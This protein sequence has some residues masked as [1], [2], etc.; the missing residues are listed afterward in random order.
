[1]EAVR[2]GKNMGR[3]V[4]YDLMR[5]ICMIFAISIHTNRSFIESAFWAKSFNTMLFS[6]N[7]IFYMLSGRF[8]LN[9][10]FLCKE[11]YKKYYWKKTISILY[12]YVFVTCILH[13]WDTYR[14]A[15]WN[16]IVLFIKT[17][18]VALMNSNVSGPLWFM[19]P[20]IGMLI[21]TPFLARMF[22][23]LSDWELN[24]LFCLSLMWNVVSIY[25]TIDF[26]I[27][28]SY[29]GFILSGW[30]I[31]FFA[32]YYCQRIV[33][34][35]NKKKFYVAGL[36]G[37]IVTVLGQVL[38]PD[39]YCNAV[40]LAPAFVLFTIALFIFMEK[41]IKISNNVIRR[42]IGSV[43]RHSF[44]IYMLHWKVIVYITPKIVR[45]SS[46]IVSYLLNVM[47]TLFISML[48]AIVLDRFIINPIQRLMSRWA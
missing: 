11:D 43:A 40:D 30:I 5:V 38:L 37:G 42:I 4:N 45:E 1:M 48:L 28:F 13:L 17:T 12:P 2:A 23:K 47:M 14:N 26:G 3:D 16:G 34:E 9:K 32:G 27:G 25:L 44:M 22:Q 21:S 20:L 6:C 36:F 46:D 19:Y 39:N 41:E 31:P 24:L 7:S 29:S 33:N 8:N 10:T 15:S 18:Y 35:K